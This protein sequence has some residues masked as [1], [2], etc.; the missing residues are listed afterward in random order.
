MAGVLLDDGTDLKV[1]TGIDD[2]SRFCIAARHVHR[3]TARAVCEVFSASLKTYGI[4]DEVLTDN[5]KVFTGRFGLHHTEV[6]F[7]RMCR[8]PRAIPE[9]DPIWFLPRTTIRSGRRTEGRPRVETRGR[10]RKPGPRARTA[11]TCP[12]ALS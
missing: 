1:V 4:P 8:L 5:E 6:V 9:E 2:H 7:D 12:R 10:N 3:A 11:F